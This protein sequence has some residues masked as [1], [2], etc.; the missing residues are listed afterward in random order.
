MSSTGS[1]VHFFP[2]LS[3]TTHFLKKYKYTRGSEV[4]SKNSSKNR[5]PGEER[6]SH[7]LVW[8][9][10]TWREQQSSNISKIT[11]NKIINNCSMTDKTS[12]GLKPR[13]KL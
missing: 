3:T 6:L 1:Q 11:A 13:Q 7:G 2:V 10:H 5:K 12:N 8:I 4:N 9:V